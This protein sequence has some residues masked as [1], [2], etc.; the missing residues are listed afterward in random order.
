MWQSLALK[1]A[2]KSRSSRPLEVRGTGRKV[3]GTG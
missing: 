3:R 1:L 2:P